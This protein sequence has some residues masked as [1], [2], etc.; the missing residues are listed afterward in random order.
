M[1]VCVRVF[2]C[3]RVMRI[4]TLSDVRKMCVCVPVLIPAAS[5]MRRNA[6]YCLWIFGSLYQVFSYT[7]KP[8]SAQNPLWGGRH[9]CFWCCSDNTLNAVHNTCTSV[10]LYFAWISV[11][12]FQHASKHS[13]CV[14]VC[15]M[16]VPC[17]DEQS[18]L[19]NMCALRLAS[20]YAHITYGFLLCTSWAGEA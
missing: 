17:Y 10:H 16:L 19:V 2:A 12:W 20:A 9:H 15:A 7:V 3:V 5:A 4:N 18:C 11:L 1:C 6:K 8:I 14:C 13:M